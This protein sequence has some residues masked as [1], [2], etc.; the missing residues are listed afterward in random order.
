MGV[1][2][3]FWL[4]FFSSSFRFPF[5]FSPKDLPSWTVVDGRMWHFIVLFSLLCFSDKCPFSSLSYYH[6]HIHLFFF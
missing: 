3:G 6:H 4:D 5:F 2:E 1:F